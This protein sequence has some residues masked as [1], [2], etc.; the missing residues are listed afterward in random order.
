MKASAVRFG[1]YIE[2][3]TE[4][5]HAYRPSILNLLF[6]HTQQS[7]SQQAPQPTVARQI[8]SPTHYAIQVALRLPPHPAT[9]SLY[10]SGV[11]P[12]TLIYVFGPSSLTGSP[13]LRQMNNLVGEIERSSWLGH[14]RPWGQKEGL[15][16]PALL[17]T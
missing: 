13:C 5:H 3:T 6:P 14:G 7:S 12:P 15:R 4:S 10:V 11:E 17:G 1:K 9:H 16:R 8:S 2:N